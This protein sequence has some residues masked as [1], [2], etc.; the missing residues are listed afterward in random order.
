MLNIAIIGAGISG[1]TVANILKDD[2]KVTVFEK[3][4]GVGGRIATRRAEPFYFDHG[5]QFFKARTEAFQSFI[6]PMLD[7]GIIQIWNARF[8]EFKQN[9][10]VNKIILDND[11]HYV[12]VPGMNAIAKY[13][14]KDIDVRVNT[15]ITTIQNREKWHLINE[16]GKC[17]GIFDWVISTAPAQ[18]T[19]DLMP[20]SF[21]H[22]SYTTSAKM[23]GCY[24]LMLGFHQPLPLDFDM[25]L[26][27][28]A[29]IGW[30][31]VNR[32]KPGRSDFFSIIV[33]S[34]NKWAELHSNDD[35]EKVM[36]YLCHETSRIIGHNVNVAAHK[37]LHHWRYAN[38]N[39]Q[40]IQRILVDKHQKLAACGDWCI[41]GSVESAFIN[42]LTVANSI[43]KIVKSK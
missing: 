32:S 15:K 8:A 14:A 36:E 39:K 10:L 42:S 16:L 29:D 37:D 26:I 35:R 4:R 34:T 2:A 30:I 6:R 20:E 7:Q 38:I 18:Q 43:L 27:R 1:L 28:E 13:L 25:A 33:H 24:S 21:N 5:A 22:H 31:S 12:G 19:A 3:S 40:S 41:Q 11:H 9:K 23:V 17:I